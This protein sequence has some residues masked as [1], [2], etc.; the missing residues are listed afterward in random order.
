MSMRPDFRLTFCDEPNRF[1]IIRINSHN[2]EQLN[3]FH[4][5][6][7][8]FPKVVNSIVRAID[9]LKCLSEGTDTIRDICN[10]THLSKSTVHR[11]LKTLE[12]TQLIARDPI[13]RRYY[14]GPL[15]LKL[16][17]NPLIV[18]QNLIMHA[19]AGM[20][21]LRDIS[22]ET[23]LLHIRVGLERI[24]LEEL[25][26]LQ[27]I[28]FT[29]GKGVT[30]PI[31]LGSAG[32][33]LLSEMKDDELGILLRNIHLRPVGPHTITDK[34]ELLRELQ[35]AREQGFSTS[36]GERLA[37]GIGISVPIKNYVCP[38]ALSILGPA[39]RIR[40]RMVDLVEETKQI[41]RE[42]SDKINESC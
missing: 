34:G 28:K 10:E 11:L 14:L 5:Q 36:Y 19:F 42:I 22:G 15:I 13:R 29:A 18:H 3:W 35:K 20:K 33:I 27:D 23:A 1:H 8:P 32:K 17:S 25:E 2:V 38:V 7:M 30:A 21:Q 6:K 12:A 9:I 4:L 24:C 26:S 31:Y 39:N 37:E 40:P 41:G 16:A